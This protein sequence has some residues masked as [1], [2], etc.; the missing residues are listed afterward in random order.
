MAVPS[1]IARPLLPDEFSL[2]FQSREPIPLGRLATF[3]RKVETEVWPIVESES[4]F[5]EL[6]EYASGSGEPRFRIVGPGRIAVQEAADLQRRA[7][8]A[9][10]R[11][12]D[13]AEKWGRRN[14]IGSMLVNPVAAA[15]AAS[16]VSGALNP[17]AKTIVYEGEVT[18]VF[19][20]TPDETRVIPA[21]E[22][23]AGRNHPK[24]VDARAHVAT[25]EILQ[26]SHSL[27]EG[28]TVR[29]AG[30][31]QVGRGG[32]TFRTLAGNKLDLRDGNLTD[33][34]LGTRGPVVIEAVV[35]SSNGTW[36]IEPVNIITHLDDF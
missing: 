3:L 29:L 8:E 16:M 10:K 14:F 26:L 21:K 27:R 15:V 18:N 1:L 2:F 7:V 33:H 22:I 28:N 31:V 34:L 19:I 32:P 9:A 5:L 24:S 12:A 20:S 35:V 23:E 4:L 6:S 25:A 36:A 17:S 11:Q 30:R 13:A